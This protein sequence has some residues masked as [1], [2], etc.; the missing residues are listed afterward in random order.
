MMC[1]IYVLFNTASSFFARSWWGQYTLKIGDV[2]RVFKVLSVPKIHVFPPPTARKGKRGGREDL[3][4]G[5]FHRCVPSVIGLVQDSLDDGGLGD[6]GEDLHR[7][8]APG[9]GQTQ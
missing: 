4:A 9:T 8:A 7:S 3:C 2:K 1:M 5:G 6:E